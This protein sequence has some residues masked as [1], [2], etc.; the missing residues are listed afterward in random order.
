MYFIYV[1]Y[2]CILYMY[3]IYV[4]TVH[5]TVYHN[6]L[7]TLCCYSTIVNCLLLA[8]LCMIQYNYVYDTL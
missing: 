2:I 6:I 4:Y 5:P 3:F 1:F 7:N 8:V